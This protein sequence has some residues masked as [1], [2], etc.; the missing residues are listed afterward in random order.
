MND[1]LERYLYKKYPELFIDHTKTIQE[2]CMPWGCS[3]GDGWFLLLDRLCQQ[4]TNHIKSQNEQFEWHEKWDAEKLAK[5]EKVEPRPEWIKKVPPVHFD[6]VKEK[7]SCLRIYHS[8]GDEEISTMISFAENLSGYICEECGRFD[9][10]VGKTTKGWIHTICYECITKTP[11][12]I[13]NK[14]WRLLDFNKDS[15]K[16]FKKVVKDGEKNKN[17]PFNEAIKKLAEVR[18]RSKKN[19]G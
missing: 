2:S 17:K 5:G 15:E 11:N 19:L 1:I 16:L 13:K 7:F 8:G 6:Q 14:G 3:H 18:K 9:S 12:D 4:I 10:T